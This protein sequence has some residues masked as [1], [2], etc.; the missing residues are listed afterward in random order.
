MLLK[1]YGKHLMSEIASGFWENAKKSSLKVG[2][3]FEI[4]ECEYEEIVGESR[5]GISE[6]EKR[7]RKVQEQSNEGL[8]DMRCLGL[9]AEVVSISPRVVN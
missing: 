5:E 9:M 6:A 3:S 4:A 2:P 7:E 8:F 1:K